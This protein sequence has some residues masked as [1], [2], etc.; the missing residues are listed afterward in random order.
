MNTVPH[1][2]CGVGF[3]CDINGKPSHRIVQLGITAVKNL[4][5]RGAVGSD[6][7]TG[8]GVGILTQIPRKF[9]KKYLQKEGLKISD[10]NNLAV[11][12]IFA[13]ESKGYKVL[14]ELL[15]NFGFKVV[16]YRAVP[17]NNEA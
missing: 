13:K 2:S 14:E 5:H 16:A 10:I 3:I 7:K 17:T 8:D 1:D 9:F 11:G 15:E 4:T 6:G 12:F